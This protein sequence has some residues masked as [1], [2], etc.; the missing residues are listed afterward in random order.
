MRLLLALVIVVIAASDILGVD[1]GLAPGLSA[2]N[3]LLYLCFGLLLVQRA[4]TRQPRI[5]LPGLQALFLCMVAYALATVAFNVFVVELPRY[6][7]LE[8]FIV[9]K[10]QYLDYFVMFIAAF[11]IARTDEDAQGLLTVL[12]AVVAIGAMLTITNVMGLTDIGLTRYGDDNEIEGGRVHGSFG[13]ANET[14]TLLILLLPAFIAMSEHA[15]GAARW[16]WLA[17]LACCAL[18]LLM[19]GSRSSLLGLMLGGGAT[20]WLLRGWFDRRRVLRWVGL[21][22]LVLLPLLVVLGAPYL[23][24]LM[25]RISTQASGNVADASSGR[26][27]LWGDAFEVMMEKPWTFIT[28]FGWGGWDQHNFS[29]VAHNQYL[30]YLFELG[31]PGAIGFA[32][33]IFGT[34]AVA[35]RALVKAPPRSRALLLA[36]IVGMASLAVSVLFVNLYKPMLYVWMFAGLCMRLAV[37]AQVAG[38]EAVAATATRDGRAATAPSRVSTI[39]PLPARVQAPPQLLR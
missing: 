29:Y 10:A 7:P 27:D 1:F 15:R 37:N 6:E 24:T 38:R 32:V 9:L 28:G 39:K 11:Y 18:M 2:K 34:C 14:G 33:L 3:L 30:A 16:A 31:L 5:Q 13:H 8:Q 12:L 22:L 20:A 26:T 21:S 23:E 17:G 35:R 25:A 19:T 36:Y 4:V